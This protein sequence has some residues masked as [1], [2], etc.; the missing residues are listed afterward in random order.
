MLGGPTVVSVASARSRSAPNTTALQL[1]RV[2]PCD[3]GAV[4]RAPEIAST[5]TLMYFQRLDRFWISRCALTV[6]KLRA[7]WELQS[8]NL[9]MG[10]RKADGASAAKCLGSVLQRG[11]NGFQQASSHGSVLATLASQ[12]SPPRLIRG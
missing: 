7:N 9:P 1:V 10:P 3:L 4:S 2:T 12:A 11:I 6:L 8:L 5:I